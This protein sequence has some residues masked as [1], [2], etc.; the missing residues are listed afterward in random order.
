MNEEEIKRIRC[1]VDELIC[2]QTKHD[3]RILSPKLNSAISR[4]SPN[5]SPGA[6]SKLHEVAAYAIEASGHSHN[7]QH[8]ISCVDDSWYFFESL[9]SRV[10]GVRSEWR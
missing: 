8:W 9:A 2:C 5:I 7:K 1:L 4:I 6:L 3:A 10:K